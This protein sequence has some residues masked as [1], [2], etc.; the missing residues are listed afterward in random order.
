MPILPPAIL[1]DAMKRDAVVDALSTIADI[2][3]DAA[4]QG[5]AFDGLP[6]VGTLIGLH[7]A[8]QSV[9]ID[10]YI[11]KVGR[12]LQGLKTLSQ[13]KREAFTDRLYAK[14]EAEKF[15]EA[16]LL[17]LERADEVGKPALLARIVAEHVRGNMSQRDCFK[18]C[19][20]VN[21][22]FSADL[23]RLR[24]FKDGVQEDVEASESLFSAGLLS[25][26]GFDGGGADQT[27][28]PGGTVY[29]LNRF[30]AL[31]AR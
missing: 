23:E 25:N 13:Q 6:V 21:R 29:A 1:L 24:D 19:S 10:L 20:S 16:V 15:A 2:G 12:F 9:E 31:L 17:L 11:R 5:G 7:R 27:V 3:I 30:G 4:V 14:G 8:K 18:L 22:V 28:R 26:Q